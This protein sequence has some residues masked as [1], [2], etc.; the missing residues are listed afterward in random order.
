MSNQSSPLAKRPKT[1]LES[2]LA[3]LSCPKCRLEFSNVDE[4]DH[5][6]DTIH[7]IDDDEAEEYEDD[8]A[9]VADVTFDDDNDV[10][11]MEMD[12]SNVTEIELTPA[13]LVGYLSN[14]ICQLTSQGIA[15]LEIS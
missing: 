5:H 14:S 4:L 7:A 3:V 11:D 13:M 15:L 2:S 6:I 10:D 9:G 12:S 1:S 8:F